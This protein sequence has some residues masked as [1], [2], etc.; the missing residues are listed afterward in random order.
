[1]PAFTETCP[2]APCPSVPKKPSSPVATPELNPPI[3]PPAR[4]VPMEVSL[5]I[6]LVSC[7]FLPSCWVLLM[8]CPVSIP[9]DVI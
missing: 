6:R 2:P 5:M 1:M 9:W 4:I 7:A 3:N 8:F